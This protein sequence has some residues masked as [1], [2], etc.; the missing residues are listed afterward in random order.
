MILYIYISLHGRDWKDN[1]IHVLL[2]HQLSQTNCSRN[3]FQS[4]DEYIAKRDKF[5]GK[6]RLD[7][8]FRYCYRHGSFKT[9]S[10]EC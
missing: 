5:A 6:I 4:T 1:F 7:G 3:S 2:I 8:S 9:A 10:N